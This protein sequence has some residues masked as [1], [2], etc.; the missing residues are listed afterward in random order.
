M[1]FT[2]NGCLEH[3]QVRVGVDADFRAGLKPMGR[4]GQ[5]TQMVKRLPQALARTGTP[6]KVLEFTAGHGPA[7]HRQVVQQGAKFGRHEL[8]RLVMP[9][10][11]RTSQKLAFERVFNHVHPI[12]WSI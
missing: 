7:L 3:L 1:M 5:T 12:S 2:M 10:Q 6:E 8:E 11:L 9:T 4:T